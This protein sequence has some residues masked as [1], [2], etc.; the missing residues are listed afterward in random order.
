MLGK[1]PSSCGSGNL[2]K[3]E[4]VYK[5]CSIQRGNIVV[6]RKSTKNLEFSTSPKRID[7][8]KFKSSIYQ[9]R[10][11]TVCYQVTIFRLLFSKIAG[12]I[13]CL[14][15]KKLLAKMKRFTFHSYIAFF[16][17]LVNKDLFRAYKGGRPK[18]E[19]KFK[20]WCRSSLNID[21]SLHTQLWNWF[22]QDYPRETSKETINTPSNQYA[23]LDEVKLGTFFSKMSRRKLH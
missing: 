21:E 13:V 10:R 16:N 4:A 8:K 2:W 15:I 23:T 19:A 22:S 17:F 6:S 18:S 5:N 12:Q 3:I 9:F 1:I 7:F 11:S 20:N 14:K